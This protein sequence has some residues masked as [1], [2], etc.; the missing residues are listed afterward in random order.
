[1]GSSKIR[2][3]WHVDLKWLFG[4][5]GIMA[6]GLFLTV[7][8]LFMA[9]SKTN[10]PELLTHVIAYN[11]SRDG[12]DQPISEAERAKV[13][14]E[15]IELLPGAKI[16][17]SDEDLQLP[18][19]ELRLKI[20]RQMA[21]PF[22][23]QGVEGL[24]DTYA[25]TPEQREKFIKD[26]YLLDLITADRHNQLG[27]LLAAI[28]LVLALI[29]GLVVFFS[30]GWGRLATP[31]VILIAAT[32]VPSML[33]GLLTIAAASPG[34]APNQAENYL[35]MLSASKG[36]LV[37]LLRVGT[38]VNLSGLLIGLLLLIAGLVARK[39]SHSRANTALAKP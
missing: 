34:P 38:V 1:M 23:T 6:A 17:L 18:S 4:L 35:D 12:I 7:L 20:F 28:G 5:L 25:K 22:Y 8:V 30:A 29:V 33:W 11:F 26:A 37:P 10:G 16:V 27:V 36:A 3:Y 13:K 21:E 9:I 24:A 19:R 14:T 39:V 2:P 32:L 15:G 31:G